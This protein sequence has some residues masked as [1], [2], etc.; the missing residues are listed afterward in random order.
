MFIPAFY[1]QIL[2]IIYNFSDFLN[3][4]FLDAFRFDNAE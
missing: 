1:Y 4:S 3:V 2:I